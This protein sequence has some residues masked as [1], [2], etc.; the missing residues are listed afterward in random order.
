MRTAEE[1]NS[2]ITLGKRI[3]DIRNMRGYSQ[4]EFANMIGKDQPSVHRLESGKT[5][6]GYLYLQQIA[7]GLSVDIKEFI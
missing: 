5:N 2:L 3:R 4:T 6:P 7:K 1:K